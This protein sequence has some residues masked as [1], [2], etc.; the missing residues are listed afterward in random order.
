[1]CEGDGHEGVVAKRLTSRYVANKAASAWRK[2]K[3]TMELVCVVVGYRM[4]PNG[5]RDLQLAAVVDRLRRRGRVGSRFILNV[6]FLAARSQ[7][8]L[9]ETRLWQVGWSGG[10]ID[11]VH[12]RGDTGGM[13]RFI[14]RFLL[15]AL[16]AVIIGFY[17]LLA[18]TPH[19]I[20][21]AHFELIKV[22]MTK[23]EVAAMFGVP[24]GQYDWAEPAS[25]ARI[26]LWMSAVRLAEAQ[27]VR[28][29]Q[30]QLGIRFLNALEAANEGGV[31]ESWV[32]RH[33]DF[34]V[35][36]DGNNRVLLD[37]RG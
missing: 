1:M 25:L 20:D 34:R 9:G 5:L 29:R 23:A 33:G 15:I 8:A 16:L 18:P 19:R 11:A 21:E 31:S 30:L 35:H 10:R 2:I 36:F 27:Q 12:R 4:G 14:S 24:A 22:G 17:S 37:N 6:R 13:R 3:Q 32:S 7:T 28:D 26:Q